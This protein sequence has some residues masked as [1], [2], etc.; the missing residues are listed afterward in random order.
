[1]LDLDRHLINITNPQTLE[2]YDGCRKKPLKQLRPYMLSSI[3]RS[4]TKGDTSATFINP[5]PAFSLGTNVSSLNTSVAAIHD[6]GISAR[7]PPLGDIS[8]RYSQEPLVAPRI[9]MREPSSRI[10]SYETSTMRKADS[11]PRLDRT[12]L[13][14]KMLVENLENDL[15]TR[16]SHIPDS[17]RLSNYSARSSKLRR[18]VATPEYQ[19]HN[20]VVRPPPLTNKNQK[21]NEM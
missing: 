9:E 8:N 19:F 4:D 12:D 18:P 2:P 1:M 11:T 6:T 10:F 7:K 17:S 21:R 13:E 5:V 16:K 20:K 3:E 15:M 14:F